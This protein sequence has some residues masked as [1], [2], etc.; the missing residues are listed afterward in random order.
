MTA[1]SYQRLP[2]LDL[3]FK[4]LQG[5]S[6]KD[7]GKK[8]TAEAAQELRSDP[9]VFEKLGSCEL[10]LSLLLEGGNVIDEVLH[11]GGGPMIPLEELRKMQEADKLQ[12][13][14]GD[15]PELVLYF[16]AI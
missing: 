9:P 7:K 2:Q 15:Q 11:C 4:C 12:V 3:A 14:G 6:A 16:D 1:Y 13:G 8:K 10:P 5:K